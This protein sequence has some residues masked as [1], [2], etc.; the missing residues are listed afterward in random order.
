MV[1]ELKYKMYRFTAKVKF[2]TST[3]Y[4]VLYSTN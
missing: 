4:K 2:Q 3:F 1:E